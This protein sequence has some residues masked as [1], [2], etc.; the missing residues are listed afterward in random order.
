MSCWAWSMVCF[1]CPGRPAACRKRHSWWLGSWAMGAAA[2]AVH[3]GWK[4]G[5]LSICACVCLWYLSRLTDSL[6]GDGGYSSPSRA[7]VWR[8]A[9]SGC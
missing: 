2:V 6:C 1:S 7:S 3:T 9:A 8:F 4:E 5:C